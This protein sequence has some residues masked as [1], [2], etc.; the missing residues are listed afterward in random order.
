MPQCSPSTLH[1]TCH[2]YALAPTPVYSPSRA[3]AGKLH[4]STRTVQLREQAGMNAPTLHRPGH[5][6]QP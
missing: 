4:M 6:H 2:A 5:V 1:V 3:R